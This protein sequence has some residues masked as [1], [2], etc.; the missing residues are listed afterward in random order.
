MLCALALARARSAGRI[1][2]PSGSGRSGWLSRAAEPRKPSTADLLAVFDSQVG[3]VREACDFFGADPAPRKP[4]DH[5]GCDLELDDTDLDRG[6]GRFEFDDHTSV[7]G[8]EVADTGEQPFRFA[9]DPD[10][11]VEQ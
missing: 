3:A 6:A 7:G 1:A 4:A 2:R 5:A 11:P 9:A 10:V 8:H